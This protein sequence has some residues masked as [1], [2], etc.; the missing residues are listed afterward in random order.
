MQY[1][2]SPEEKSKVNKIEKKN[3]LI[4]FDSL[5]GTSHPIFSV[6]FDKFVYNAQNKTGNHGTN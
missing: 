5:K 4:I 2:K 3:H 6:G 1:T